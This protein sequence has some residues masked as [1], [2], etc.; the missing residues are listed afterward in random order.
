M[1]RY[2][3]IYLILSVCY[4]QADSLR[5]D[6]AG[7]VRIEPPARPAYGNAVHIFTDGE[8]WTSV[9]RGAVLHLPELKIADQS[10]QEQVKPSFWQ[11]DSFRQL[12]QSADYI[13]P[14]D[15][16]SNHENVELLKSSDAVT[17]PFKPGVLYILVNDQDIPTP[18]L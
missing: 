11:I 7:M 6:I 2:L 1:S 16:F 10:E 3:F 8:D 14:K 5:G 13:E 18:E 15:F 17:E 9:V 4:L 12:P